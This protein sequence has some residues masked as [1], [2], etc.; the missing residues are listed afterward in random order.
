MSVWNTGLTPT[1]VQQLQKTYKNIEFIAGFKDDGS[2]PSKLNT[3]QVKNSSMVFNQ[4][5]SV[6]LHH[7]CLLYTSSCV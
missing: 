3:P 1:E 4:Q 2:N 6:K 5:L 7:P